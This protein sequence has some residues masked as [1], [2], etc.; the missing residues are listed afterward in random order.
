M[1]GVQT[2]DRSPEDRREYGAVEILHIL[3]IN[4]N[5]SRRAHDA[6]TVKAGEDGISIILVSEPNQAAIQNK[7]GWITSTGGGAAIRISNGQ[8]TP[9]QS[10]RAGGNHVSVKIA[11]VRY[12]ASYVSP[13]CTIEQ[14]EIDLEDLEEDLNSARGGV[15]IGGDF[16]AKSSEWG[17]PRTDRTGAW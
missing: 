15:I 1:P 10:Y 7:R 8:S 3:Q 2:Y 12:Y 4:L 6:A 14:F 9:V 16:N 5:R 11:G 17:A 13:N